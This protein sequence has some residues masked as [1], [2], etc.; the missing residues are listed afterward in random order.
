MALP[1]SGKVTITNI[2]ASNV[3]AVRFAFGDQENGGSNW[4]EIDVT[5]TPSSAITEQDGTWTATRRRQLDG[6][7]QLA[8]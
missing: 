8:R 2:G 7:S 5:G 6:C 3:V 4:A 1:G